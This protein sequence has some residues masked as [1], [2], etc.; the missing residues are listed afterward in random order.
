[1]NNTADILIIDDTPDNL[2]FLGTILTK[3][4]YH[5]RKALDGEMALIACKNLLPDLILLDIMMPEMDGYQVCQE[6][7]SNP[8][9][10]KIP[11]IFLSA[12]ND[13]AVSF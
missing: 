11:I 13:R 9:T 4:G 3:Q 8:L 12:I 10:N 6:L 7:K 1:M 5:V 2:R